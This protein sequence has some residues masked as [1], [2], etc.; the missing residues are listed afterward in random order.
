MF[1]K[2]K[3][4]PNSDLYHMFIFHIYYIAGVSEPQMR[5]IVRRNLLHPRTPAVTLKTGDNDDKNIHI[6][7]GVGAVGLVVLFLAMV[8]CALY[9]KRRYMLTAYF[10]AKFF[11]A[12]GCRERRIV[13][14]LLVQLITIVVIGQA[15]PMTK[16]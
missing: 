15:C 7:L 4:W 3:L 1:G 5:A 2:I 10:H 13:Q 12:Q 8:T 11:F 14:K 16:I 9:Y 6:L